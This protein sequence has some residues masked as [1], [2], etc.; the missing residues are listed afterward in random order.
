MR[1][2]PHG[3][4]AGELRR[5][6]DVVDAAQLRGRLAGGVGPRD[7]AAVAVDAR[8]GVDDDE[9]TGADDPLAGQRV[10]LGA[11]VAGGDDGGERL[12]LRPQAVVLGLQV[13]GHVALGAADEPARDH[14]LQPLVGD[15][16]R[17][18]QDGDLL[19][20]LDRAEQRDALAHVTQGTRVQ[21]AQLAVGGVTELRPLIPEAGARAEHAQRL[22]ARCARATARTSPC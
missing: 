5:E 4:E 6:D 12:A 18:A 20:V 15:R 19:L 1:A 7:V 21:A 9:L 17:A 16:G 22:R 10:R 8:A 14:A 13:P 2:G 3:G 11:V